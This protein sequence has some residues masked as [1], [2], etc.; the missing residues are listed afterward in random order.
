MTELV[1]KLAEVLK[2]H[3]S[4]LISIRNW[5]RQLLLERKVVDDLFYCCSIDD[6]INSKRGSGRRRDKEELYRLELF[7][8]ELKKG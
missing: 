5:R 3:N 1:R 2:K 6:I 4:V 7:R 8:E